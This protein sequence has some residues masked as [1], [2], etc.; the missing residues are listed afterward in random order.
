MMKKGIMFYLN[1]VNL[2]TR[3]DLLELDEVKYKIALFR[4]ENR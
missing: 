3:I 4:K 1:T 2:L